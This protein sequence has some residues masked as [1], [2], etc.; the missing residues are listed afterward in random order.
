MAKITTMLESPAFT[1]RLRQLSPASDLAWLAAL[2]VSISSTLVAAYLQP[3]EGKFWVYGGLLLRACIYLWSK[4]ALRGRG[5]ETIARLFAMGLVAG[6]LELLVDRASAPQTAH[7]L[8]RRLIWSRVEP[9]DSPGRHPFMEEN[10]GP[11]FPTS[12][13]A[14]T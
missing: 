10:N 6:V 3:S 14:A 12:S 13:S 11:S 1:A 8:R 9:Y 4:N 5:G 7:I 2:L